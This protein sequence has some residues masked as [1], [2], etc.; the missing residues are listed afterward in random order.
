MPE[1]PEVETTASILNKLV[2]NKKILDVWT[3]YKSDYHAGKENIKDPNFFKKF[4][5]DILNKKILRV[6]RRAKNVLIDIEGEKTIL[7]H[8]KMTG[9]LLYSR[10]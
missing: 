10:Y 8:M 7:I 9:H 1:L 2:S 4:Q 6:W 3:D 5:K